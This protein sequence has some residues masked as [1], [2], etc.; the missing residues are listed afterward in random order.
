MGAVHTRVLGEG[1]GDVMLLGT[2]MHVG[3]RS[4]GSPERKNDDDGHTVTD[5]IAILVDIDPS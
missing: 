5:G 1:K 3:P 2:A 4:L